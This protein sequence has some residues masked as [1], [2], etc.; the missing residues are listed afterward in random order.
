MGAAYT[1]GL[2]VSAGTIVRKIRRLP[3]KGSVLVAVGDEVTPDTVVALA[4]LPGIMRNVR[5]AEQLGMEP[6]DALPA[7]KVKTGDM[8]EVGDLLAE[9]KSFF[10]LFK[11]EVKSPVAGTVEM[12][13]EHTGHVGVRLPPTPVQVKAYIKGRVAEVIPEEGA[14]IETEAA[15]VQG[16]FGVGG[17][18]VGEIMVV[19]DNPSDV[20][21]ESRIGPDASGKILIGGSNIGGAALKKAC[22]MGAIGVVVGA[23]I[24]KDLTD[25]LGYD[26]GVA[27]T[28]QED[29]DATLIVTEGFGKIPMAE[30]TFRL[31]K[32]LEGRQASINGA[33][34]IRAGVIR[35]EIISPLDK[36]KAA[37][38]EAERDS[39]ELAVGAD[40][41]IIREPYFGVLGKVAA[42]PPEPVQIDSGAVVRV[43]EADLEDGRRV[44][45]PRANVE[46]IEKG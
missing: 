42:L 19:V 18:R 11:T 8:V 38:K 25:F 10:G 5:V 46:I 17:E 35:P 26:I 24:D 1:P 9:T 4:E 37:T 21:D 7:M 45:V 31:L 22:E 33:T 30:R 6:A 13:S 12:I 2:K 40:I 41:R 20:L 44:A 39:Q 29:I 36:L 28:G 43:L 23:I 27:I 16:I 34:Q 15:F 14:V 3:L 32:S